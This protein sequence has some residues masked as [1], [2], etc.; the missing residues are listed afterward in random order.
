MIAAQRGGA[1]RSAPQLA[2]PR[3]YCSAAVRSSALCSVRKTTAKDL[4]RSLRDH[5][6]QAW[7]LGVGA[8]G[9]RSPSRQRQR[10]DARRER[11]RGAHALPETG[12]SGASASAANLGRS[13][14]RRDDFGLVARGELVAL[15]RPGEWRMPLAV[16]VATAP[17][18]RRPHLRLGVARCTL[19]TRR[20][21]R[22]ARIQR[23]G[24]PLM[25]SQTGF[26]RR[27]RTR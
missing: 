18:V 9:S 24:D 25:L 12:R 11:R 4:G 23:P 13:R 22:Q 2:R 19:S 3:R 1:A 26:S 14:K 10:A 7:S 21:R 27:S 16:R 6:A 17:L 20:R 15:E 8:L 5:G